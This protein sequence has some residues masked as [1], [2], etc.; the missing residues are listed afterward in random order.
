VRAT[1]TV[2]II[3]AGP[4]G[5]ALGTLLTR[6]GARVVVFDAGKRPELVV[7][8]SLVPAVI[9]ILREL[10]IED[11]V[12]AFSMFKPGAS[13]FLNQAHELTVIFSEGTRGLPPYSYN[14]PRDAFDALLVETAKKAGVQFV[15]QRAEL[16]LLPGERVAL[17]GASRESA[18]QIFGAA[19]EII[20]DASGRARYLPKI[21]GMG[22]TQ[23]KRKDTALFAHVDQTALRYPGH[24]HIDRCAGAGVGESRF[25]EGYRLAW[26]FPESALKR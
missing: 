8:E 26:W 17:K 1:R 5:C 4:A 3:G 18:E 11:Q 9:P 20:V 7:G 22:A 15:E 13:F 21:L 16:Q 6:G 19:P 10:G 12:R 24:I 25:P 14:V 23:G 2:A